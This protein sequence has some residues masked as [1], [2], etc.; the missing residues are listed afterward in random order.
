MS[1]PDLGTI[2]RNILELQDGAIGDPRELTPWQLR[3]GMWYK[4]E[5]MHRNA[6]GVNGAKFRACRH[7]ITQA[8]IK[9]GVDTI[10][11]AQSV[12]SPQAA[13]T[14]TL[15]EEMDLD[16]YVVVGA[17]KP[18]TAIN[19][20]S[21]R[22]AVQAGAQ[23]D[24]SRK[25][26]YNGVI[27]PY[28]AKLAEELGGWQVPYAISPPA[29]ASEEELQGFLSVGGA[30]VTN[31]PHDVKTLVIPFGSGNSTAGVL[32]GLSCLTHLVERVILVGVGPDRTEWLWSQLAKVGVAPGDLPPVEH[33]QLHDWF[34]EYADLMPE[35]IDG[36][37]MHPTYEGKV[38][39]YLNMVKPEW[40]TSRDGSTGFW[41]VGGPI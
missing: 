41:I 22:I 39:R 6:Y 34:A 24:T 15:C 31:L 5:D 32:Y 25:V 12:R 17:S 38:V 14:A 11:T 8:V 35:T 13:I 16:C 1:A 23:L 10:V 3:D 4:R 9:H 7:L 36:I 26:A 18:E 20:V 29:D 19:H 2:S 33:L 27:Q 30:Q 40:W 28:G 21:V 37:V